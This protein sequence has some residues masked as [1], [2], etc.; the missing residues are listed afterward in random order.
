MAF[1]EDIDYDAMQTKDFADV[2]EEIIDELHEND[3]FDGFLEIS[4]HFDKYFPGYMRN[5]YSDI[6]N[7]IKHDLKN[8][9]ELY[10]YEI[11]KIPKYVMVYLED[12]LF[13]F[14]KEEEI[15][16]NMFNCLYEYL[17]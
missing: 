5:N 3:E 7:F 16:L 6:Y 11:Y 4:Y 9:S 8:D 15:S 13:M 17:I 14:F 2:D 12:V 1:Y 10:E